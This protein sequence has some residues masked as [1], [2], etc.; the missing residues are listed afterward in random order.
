MERRYFREITDPTTTNTHV[1]EQNRTG[2]HELRGPMGTNPVPPATG[3]LICCPSGC[4]GQECS[5][6]RALMRQ[7]AAELLSFNYRIRSLSQKDYQIPSLLPD[8]ESI[9]IKNSLSHSLDLL[10]RTDLDLTAY[11]DLS[12]STSSLRAAPQLP[13]THAMKRGQPPVGEHGE[14]PSS[15]RQSTA[16]SRGR[17]G[18]ALANMPLDQSRSY[19]PF[20]VDGPPMTNLPHIAA[21]PAPAFVAPQSPGQISQVSRPGALPS[22]SSI[23]TNSQ[24]YASPFTSPPVAAEASAQSSH[25]QD[26]QHQV[27][28]KTLAFQTLQ[29]EYDSLLQRLE[30]QQIKCTTL[31]KKFEVSD[32]EI[33]TLLDEKEKLQAQVASLETQVEELQQSRDET[34]RELVTN[35]AQYM[36]I[37]E[38]ANRLQ[39]QGAEDKRRWE[40]EKAE[41]RQRIRVLEEAMVTGHDEQDLSQSSN[42]MAHRTGESSTGISSTTE[43]LSVLRNEVGRLRLRTKTLEAALNTMKEETFTIQETARKLAQSGAKIEGLTRGVLSE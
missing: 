19:H 32:V 12:L 3:G 7:L 6:A 28:V 35:G 33:N 21:A 27:S 5:S 15:S 39:N 43:T 29:R 4:R 23:T 2:S 13:D 31:E 24:S 14:R 36:R 22:P 11:I 34:R 9:D 25:L 30:R 40:T 1:M 17:S 10:R 37:V 41:L 38:M 42:T 20:G 16:S 8:V 18:F 26:L